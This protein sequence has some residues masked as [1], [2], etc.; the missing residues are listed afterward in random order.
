[1]DSRLRGN[2]G[3][4]LRARNYAS[5]IQGGSAGRPVW[6]S[7]CWVDGPLTASGVPSWRSA[8]EPA[9]VDVR[10]VRYPRSAW[11]SPSRRCRFARKTPPAGRQPDETVPCAGSGAL[12]QAA[13]LP[14]RYQQ[15]FLHSDLQQPKSTTGKPLVTIDHLIRSNSAPRVAPGRFIHRV[16]SPFQAI[17]RWG[18]SGSNP[19]PRLQ[20][21]RHGRRSGTV[22][23]RTPWWPSVALVIS[24]PAICE[25]R[26]NRSVSSLANRTTT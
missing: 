21:G 26:D 3:W 24:G 6:N 2:D 12:S 8:A 22:R 7:Q 20:C 13:A 15:E 16:S 14:D 5:F 10:H 17:M 9:K 18:S 23:L 19:K 1:M 25:G 11:K 4:S